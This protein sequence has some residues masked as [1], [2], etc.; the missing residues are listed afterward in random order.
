MAKMLVPDEPITTWI[1][2]S[3]EPLDQ[4]VGGDPGARH[5]DRRGPVHDVRASGGWREFWSK[6]AFILRESTVET[7]PKPEDDLFAGLD[8]PGE[9]RRSQGP[10]LTTAAGPSRRTPGP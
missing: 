10:S 6:E 4:Q 9:R 1:D 8:S 5:P 2:I 3:G 7:S